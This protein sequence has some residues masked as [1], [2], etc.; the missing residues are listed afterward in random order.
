MKNNFA[1]LQKCVL[2]SGIE[3]EDLSGL[4]ACLGARVSSYLKNQVIFSEGDP[5]G[6]IGIVLS[7]AVQIAREDPFGNRSILARAE[8]AELFAESYALADVDTLPVSVTAAENSRIML[9]NAHRIT[10]SCSNACGFHS[11][12]I[13][14]MLQIV[15]KK[16]LAFHQK[17]E[18]TAKRTTRE[19]LMAYLLLQA[20][21]QGSNS[22]TIPYDRQ[23]LADYLG[24]ER[25]A[26]SAEIGKLRKDGILECDRSRF[27]L[28]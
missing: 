21:Q 26:M 19:K 23:G 25:S 17:I 27:T 4:L 11:R 15:A 7:G 2:F 10:V 12:L 16:N 14:N 5:A 22:F 18:I 20:K 9:I 3:P 8:P 6:F 28:L 1:I 24:V 13:R